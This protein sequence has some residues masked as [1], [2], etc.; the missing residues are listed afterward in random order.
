MVGRP[1]LRGPNRYAFERSGAD[2]RDRFR[3]D[4]LLLQRFSR[5]GRTVTSGGRRINAHFTWH[6][7]R[8]VTFEK[9][10]HKEVISVPD[11]R[12]DLQTQQDGRESSLLR[13][14]GRRFA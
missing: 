7:W 4:Q 13:R 5:G 10:V 9:V 8:Q 11:A 1:A 2:E 12:S 6:R 3:V 14:Y